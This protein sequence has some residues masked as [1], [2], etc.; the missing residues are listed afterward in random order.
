MRRRPRYQ[1]PFP[2]WPRTYVSDDGACLRHTRVLLE[3]RHQVVEMGGVPDLR[4]AVVHNAIGIA[5]V[6]T[7]EYE[8]A[9]A[10]FKSSIGDFKGL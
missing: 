9:T 4:L 2:P 1:T 3:M 7:G 10:A 6:M 5:W 8:N